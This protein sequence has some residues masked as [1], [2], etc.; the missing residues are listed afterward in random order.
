MTINDLIITVKNIFKHVIFGYGIILLLQAVV[1]VYQ[2]LN[3][4]IIT[5]LVNRWE[6]GVEIAMT[7][8]YLTKF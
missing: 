1:S 6:G 7:G 3:E 5:G 8:V 2:T 4:Y